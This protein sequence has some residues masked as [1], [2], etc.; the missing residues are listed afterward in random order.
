MKFTRPPLTIE[1]QIRLLKHGGVAVEDGALAAHHLKHGKGRNHSARTYG[2]GETILVSFLR[3]LGIVPKLCAYH[4]RLWNR[5]FV[6]VFRLR[7]RAAIPAVPV[8]S[9]KAICKL[10]NTLAKIDCLYPDAP[11]PAATYH[12]DWRT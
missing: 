6:F 12:P 1:Q 8:I 3:H 10:Y 2:L 5:D 11:F 9:W 7:K 4:S